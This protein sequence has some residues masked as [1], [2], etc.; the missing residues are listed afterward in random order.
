MKL[1]LAHTTQWD[2]FIVLHVVAEHD[3]SPLANLSRDEAKALHAELT[4]Q[5]AGKDTVSTL[6]RKVTRLEKSLRLA[7][8]RGA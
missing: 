8:K 6:E 1:A 7:R 3:V 4:R 5:L 2:R